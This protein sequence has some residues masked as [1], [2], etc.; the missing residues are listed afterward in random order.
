ML[1]IDR[2]FGRPSARTFTIPPVARLLKQEVK[3]S[4]RVCEP[5]PYRSTTDCFEYL[6]SW[7]TESADV[8]LLDPPYTKRQVSDHYREHNVKVT[9][10]HTSSGW[11]AK[12]K[13]EAARVIREG[14]IG[15]TFGYNSNGMGKI[16][17]MRPY[18]ILMCHSAGD[19]YDL[20]V[21][22]ER[23]VQSRLDH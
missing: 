8:V 17:G 23:K 20:L 21:T 19:H 13:A 2:V 14:G 12:V 4:D 3:K 18:R 9:G 5:F 10:W 7:D 16:N 22:C 15:I 1:R 6:R 11:T